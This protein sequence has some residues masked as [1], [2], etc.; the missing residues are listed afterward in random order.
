MSIINTCRS[1]NISNRDAEGQAID[2]ENTFKT[3]KMR[4][5]NSHT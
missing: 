2:N 1:D 4:F 3:E 5:I